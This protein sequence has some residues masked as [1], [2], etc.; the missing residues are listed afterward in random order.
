MLSA[1]LVVAPLSLALVFAGE[2]LSASQPSSLGRLLQAIGGLALLAVF[3]TLYSASLKSASRPTGREL[4]KLVF[5][6]LSWSTFA[7]SLLLSTVLFWWWQYVYH[8]AWRLVP[9]ISSIALLSIVFLISSLTTE[10]MDETLRSA[11]EGLRTKTHRLSLFFAANVFLVLAATALGVLAEMNWQKRSNVLVA[12]VEALLSVALFVTALFNT[13]GLGGSVKFSRWQFWNPFVGGVRFVVLQFFSWLFFSISV[14]L[15]VLFIVSFYTVGLEIFVGVMAVSGMLCII[16]ELLMIISLH[17][18]DEEQFIAA[19]SREAHSSLLQYVNRM[20]MFLTVVILINVQYIPFTSLYPI[21]LLSGMTFLEA[22]CH[23]WCACVSISLY[24]IV[25]LY[26][27]T[28]DVNSRENKPLHR[29]RNFVLSFVQGIPMVITSAVAA[30]D[31]YSALPWAIIAIIHLLYIQ[32]TYKQQP[33]ISGSRELK[34]H[35]ILYTFMQHTDKLAQ[36]FF[37]G[38]VIK[39]AD[40]DPQ[41][42]Y[43]FGY[44]PHGVIPVSLFWLRNSNDWK[45]LF[46]GVLFYTLTASS[47]HLVP[48]M[49]DLLQWR[50]GRE[51]SLPSFLYSLR[52]KC[53]VLV[54]PGGQTELMLSQPCQKSVRLSIKHQGF[55]RIAIQEGASIVPMFSFGEHD[56]L[57]NVSVPTIQRWFVKRF[58]AALPFHPHNGYMLPVPRQEKITVV[59]G[60]P[61]KVRQIVNPTAEDIREVLHQYLIELRRIF[62]KHK[63]QTYSQ[64][65][66]ELI[67]IDAKGEAYEISE[68]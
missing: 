44:H 57:Y 52:N 9:S 2:A 46:P 3:P 32:I 58:G 50:G 40:L 10:D 26:F 33:E 7:L 19:S 48:I 45:S 11:V 20:H 28:H 8:E 56:V 60:Q 42:L 1:S 16:A 18:Y 59:V 53:N 22:F 36:E 31:L 27:K 43:V 15:A 54:V 21:F 38:K 12:S 5:L 51:V 55:I 37:S 29:V 34:E 4:S 14:I 41:E 67:F 23:W 6:A 25:Y 13:H 65:D 49:R 47:L 63:N 62:N 61:I 68:K 30:N 35:H 66:R 17:T 39:E 24:T 64:K